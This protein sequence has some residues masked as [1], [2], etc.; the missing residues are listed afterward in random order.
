MLLLFLE[1]SV[2][3]MVVCP[4]EKFWLYALGVKIGITI[5][6]NDDNSKSLF[7]KMVLIGITLQFPLPMRNT[8]LLGI[9]FL[10]EKFHGLR[11]LNG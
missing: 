4:V 9:G 5:V 11:P 7:I 10:W 6:S 2:K 8:I 1:A 3:V